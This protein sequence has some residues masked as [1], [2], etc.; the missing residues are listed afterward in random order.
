MIA[1]SAVILV[2]PT[3]VVTVPHPSLSPSLLLFSLLNFMGGAGNEAHGGS[4]YTAI[5][6]LVLM[7]RLQNL[8][9]D[10]RA[11]LI[12]WCLMRQ[13][14]GYN[15]RTNKDNDSCYSFWIGATL[16]LLGEF[17]TTDLASARRFLLA[18]CQHK[19]LGGFAKTPGAP[20]D[21]LHTFYSLCWLSMAQ[22]S[23]ISLV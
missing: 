20:P 15:G 5:A 3:A 8:G 18:Q 19:L 23:L 1:S 11:N 9:T 10:R 17:A 22:V 4:T 6:S 14:E 7:N 21:V 12:R 13:N 2:F 16:H